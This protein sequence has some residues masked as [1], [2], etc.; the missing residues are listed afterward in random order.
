MAI[1]CEEKKLECINIT[2]ESTFENDIVKD[3]Y[4]LIS[5]F[6][7]AKRTITQLQIQK[8]MYFFE[9]FYMNEKGTNTLYDC[10]FNAWMFGPVA[11]PLYKR[12][13]EFGEFPI[14]LTNEEIELGYS[15][16]KEKKEMLEEIFRALGNL[17]SAQL[18]NLTHM[19]GSPW[20]KKWLDNNQK[21][22]NGKSSYIDKIATRDWF[23]ELFLKNE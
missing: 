9:A 12:Y 2:E 21:I 6:N 15:I 20:H 7:K 8:L 3:S 16:D 11:I 18:V 10:H 19:P 22:V 23:R 5:L 14:E 17:S 4:Y 1:I 13:K